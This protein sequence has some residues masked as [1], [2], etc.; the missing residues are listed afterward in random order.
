VGEWVYRSTFPWRWLV[1]FTPLPLYPRGKS[2]RYPLDRRLWGPRAGMNDAENIKFLTL[3]GL[4]LRPLGRPARCQSLYRLRYQDRNYILT[5]TIFDL[6]AMNSTLFWYVNL[7]SACSQMQLSH[8]GKRVQL[9]FR[10]NATPYPAWDVHVW[11]Q[12]VRGCP[13][14]LH[15]RVQIL[16]ALDSAMTTSLNFRPHLS[17]ASLFP[18]NLTHPVLYPYNINN[19]KNFE[20]CRNINTF[21]FFII[22]SGVRLSPLGIT[23]TSGLLYQPQVIDDSNYGATGGVKTGRGNL[24]RCHFV[25]HKSHMSWPALESGPPRWETSD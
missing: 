23:P 22:L 24:P 25:H 5:A 15:A 16:P 11:I 3:P 17:L 19:Q 20:T 9:A 14:N 1:S 7:Y 2:P 13:Q 10:R 21:L 6:R 4:E 18:V 8:E 12:D